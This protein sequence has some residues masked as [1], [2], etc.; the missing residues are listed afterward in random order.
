MKKYQSVLGKEIELTEERK[1]HILTFHPDLVPHFDKFPEVFLSPDKVRVSVTDPKVL[2][3]YKNF[4]TIGLDKYL[5]IPVKKNSRW[6]ILT[7]Y[8]TKRLV[9]KDYEY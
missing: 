3:F 7:A 2:L 9:G 6:F 4:A 8:L 1:H 5:C